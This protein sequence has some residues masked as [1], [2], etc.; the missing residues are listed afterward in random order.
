[1]GVAL[2]LT[3]SSEGFPNCVTMW[4]ISMARAYMNENNLTA[5]VKPER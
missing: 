2:M 3:R 4:M 1:M 5:S